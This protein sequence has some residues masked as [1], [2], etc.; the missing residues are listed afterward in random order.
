MCRVTLLIEN[1]ARDERRSVRKQQPEAAVD[2]QT[3]AGARGCQHNKR[4]ETEKREGS[5][6]AIRRKEAAAHRTPSRP[7]SPVFL[8]GPVSCCIVVLCV[9]I[10]CPVCV[11]VCE[12][13]ALLRPSHSHYR[14]RRRVPLLIFA[15]LCVAVFQ[16][17]LL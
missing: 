15:K 11:C 4:G 1:R 13:V 5:E 8:F 6:K 14:R 17:L 16:S 2:G 7:V 3:E 10:C 9:Q 12:S